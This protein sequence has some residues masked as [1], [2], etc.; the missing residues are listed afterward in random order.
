MKLSIELSEKGRVLIESFGKGGPG[1]FVVDK[2]RAYRI[3]HT[4][5]LRAMKRE[6]R[7]LLREEM[8]ALKL[9]E[10]VRQVTQSKEAVTVA[11]ASIKVSRMT[12]VR[13]TKRK[14]VSWVGLDGKRSVHGGAFKGP[15]GIIFV[16]G[17]GTRKDPRLPIHP[18][19]SGN[20]AAPFVGS[21]EPNS[22]RVQEA[23]WR[24]FEAALVRLAR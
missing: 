18:L 10:A 9:S 12:G 3:A 19:Y 1:P 24:A 4:D 5:A 2:N 23:G 22:S 8:P 11:G 16:R 7:R 21:K 15:N 17:K 6:A 14:G 13:A 20:T